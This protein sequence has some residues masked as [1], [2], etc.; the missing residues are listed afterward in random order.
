M[1]PNFPYEPA[2]TVFGILNP[3][4]QQILHPKA[5]ASVDDCILLLQ[6]VAGE[7]P[8]SEYVSSLNFALNDRELFKKTV[9]IRERHSFLSEAALSLSF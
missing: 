5:D 1:S 7:E 3:L 8:A 9:N 4:L 2:S 6:V